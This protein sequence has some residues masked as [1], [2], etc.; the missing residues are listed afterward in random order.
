MVKDV[1]GLFR[2]N[3]EILGISRRNTAVLDTIAYSKFNKNIKT[4]FDNIGSFQDDQGVVSSSNQRLTD[5]YYYQDYSYVVKSKT[6][7]NSWRDLIKQTTHPAGF[8]LFGEVLIESDTSV[9]MSPNT[10]TVNTSIVQLWDPNKNKITVV[11]TKKQVTTSVIH[12]E[13]LKIERGAGSISLDTL[14][15]LRLEQSSCS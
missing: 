10:K 1:T 7:I 9:P 13:Q 8:Q 11:S 5:S 6:S 3:T 14:I 12:T 2:E 4:Y 15:H